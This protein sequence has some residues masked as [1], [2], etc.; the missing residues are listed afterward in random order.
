MTEPYVVSDHPDM[1]LTANKN[2]LGESELTNPNDGSVSEENDY[3]GWFSEFR[4]IAKSTKDTFLPAF[5]GIANL[6]H[7][8]AM[9]VA[10]EIAQLEHDAE[11]DADRWREENYGSTEEF[12]T[13]ESM[14]L[15]W[16]L[17]VST[18]ESAEGDKNKEFMQYIEN[19]ELKEQLFALSTVEKTF[20]EPFSPDGAE[21][22]DTPFTLNEP[23]IQLI[24]RL[25]HIDVN[26]S[27]IHAKISGAFAVVFIFCFLFLSRRD[28]HLS[29]LS[30]HSLPQVVAT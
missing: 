9:A 17:V 12:A 19:E 11:L 30:S 7:R 5:D 14:R 21:E 27:K 4:S 18:A 24:R 29:K 2:D 22:D 3:T 13:G 10:A 8:S 25:L 23:R 6:V 20:L 16:E 26:L 1:I 15:P 28:S